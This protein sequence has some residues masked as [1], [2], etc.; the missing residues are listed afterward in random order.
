LPKKLRFVVA[1]LDETQDFQ[2]HQAVDARAAAAR[3]DIDLDIRFAENNA[4]LQI[5]QLYRAI[6]T[7]EPPQAI[8][9]ESVAGEGLERLAR[10]AAAAG[11]GWVIINRKVGYCEALRR[12]Y[13][14]LPIGSIGTDQLEIGRIQG[15]Q[16]RALLPNGGRVLYVQGPPDTSAA[17]Q[18]RQG[19]EGALAGSRVELTV[20][21]GQWTE[22]SGAT[23]VERWLRLKQEVDAVGCQNDMMAVGAGRALASSA[24]LADARWMPRTGVD[25]LPDGGQKLVRMGQLAAT[26][27][28]P[29]NTGPGLEALVRFFR[30]GV[31][32]PAETLLMPSSFPEVAELARLEDGRSRRA[33]AR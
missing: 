9:V 12:E 27:A 3:L 20:I 29:S 13:P 21:E 10:T 18:R 14:G 1:L 33:A 32:L 8:L 25:G 11:I 24:S 2:R 17:Q 30:A 6:R 7:D 19:A 31:A 15:R 22:A 4:I 28:V 5:Q 16:F 23:A 26:V